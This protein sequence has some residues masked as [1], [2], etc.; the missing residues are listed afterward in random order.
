MNLW[1]SRS[2]WLLTE[3]LEETNTIPASFQ[4]PWEKKQILPAYPA[5]IT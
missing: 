4:S 3:S 5:Q 2:M 1:S